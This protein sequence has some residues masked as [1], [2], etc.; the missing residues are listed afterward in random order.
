M[1]GRAAQSLGDPGDGRVPRREVALRPRGT[2]EPVERVVR[3]LVA[4]LGVEELAE[5]RLG[6]GDGDEED[7][8]DAV[9]LAFGDEGGA[10]ADHGR[11]LLREEGVELGGVGSRRRRRRER[12]R[13]GQGG[14]QQQDEHRHED[15][16]DSHAVD[17]LLHPW[18]LLPAG[19]SV[20]YSR[21]G[22]VRRPGTETAP[23]GARPGDG[24]GRRSVRA[25]VLDT[26]AAG[27]MRP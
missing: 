4:V 3:A 7:R 25:M 10:G 9:H 11:A 22:A 16:V 14:G 15:A 12:E 21:A 1:V 26:G 17:S 19:T 5:A 27:R 24:H 13:A 18:L 20:K 6:A 2:V 8:V 23:G